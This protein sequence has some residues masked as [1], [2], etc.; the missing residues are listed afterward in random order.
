MEPVKLC[1][2]A[3]SQ[4][5]PPRKSNDLLKPHT[6]SHPFSLAKPRRKTGR[7]LLKKDLDF[8]YPQVSNG[9]R[10][11]ALWKLRAG[12]G[13]VVQLQTAPGIAADATLLP[14]PRR[15]LTFPGRL[16]EKTCE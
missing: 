8:S 15:V 1:V 11:E 9:V 14:A 16:C 7:N 3:P 13:K 5:D 4:S 10:P 6:L 12:E 2:R